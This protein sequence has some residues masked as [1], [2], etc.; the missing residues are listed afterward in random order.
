MNFKENSGRN[1]IENNAANEWVLRSE[2]L[3]EAF[4]EL[5]AQ[6]WIDDFRVETNGKLDITATAEQ[7]GIPVYYEM[8]IINGE[9]VIAQGMIRGLGKERGRVPIVIHLNPQWSSDE[10]NL[11]FGHE[12]G[13]LFLETAANIVTGEGRDD[14]V[15]A[16][17]EFF[18]RQMVVPLDQISEVKEV[19]VEAVTEL[20]AK[21]GTRHTTMIYQLMLAG[22]M[23]VEYFLIRA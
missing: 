11:T 5:G 22:K 4:K 9:R 23:P 19:N 21:F 3:E 14:K 8:P 13:H 7:I 10:H 2:G 1:P 15:E 16:F 20:M 6:D 18:G 17:C 12:L